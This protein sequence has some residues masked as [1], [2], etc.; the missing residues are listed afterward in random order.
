[1]SNS[2]G[3]FD[4]LILEVPTVLPGLFI[5]VGSL[6]GPVCTE[7]Q[8]QRYTPED[9]RFEISMP[10]EPKFSLQYIDTGKNMLP[11]NMVSA[12]PDMRD[13]F[14]VSWTDYSKAAKM[15]TASD[16]TFD[17]MRD[18]LAQQKNAQVLSERSV[19]LRGNP[20]RFF[21]MRTE[22]G[23]VADVVFYFTRSRVYQVMAQTR[24][25][26]ESKQ[27]RERFIESFK[28]TSDT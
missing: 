3:I 17:K 22:D 21:T 12:N 20:G 9:A 2:A 6:S 16:R 8:W 5:I 18:A 25:G 24:C 28:L 26:D 10:A 14:L 1:M 11:L 7:P 19:T 27:S 23:Q 15:P 4:Q 13:D